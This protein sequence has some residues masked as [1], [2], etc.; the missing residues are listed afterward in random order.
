MNSDTTELLSG[1]FKLAKTGMQATKA[2]IDKADNNALK[3]QLSRQY[4]DYV[5]TANA[6]EKMLLS[7]GVVAA[8]NNPMTKAIMWGSI[9]L[10]TLG[11]V[12]P[13]HISEI[14]ING[15]TMGII[16]LTKHLNACKE[17]SEQT[18]SFAYDFIKNEETHIDELKH[19]LGTV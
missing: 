11:E 8:D 15:T 17:A 10:H 18:K 1:I 14:M 12:S 6:S 9:Q 7:E 2:V 5:E 4:I 16:D 13:S 3:E 19:F